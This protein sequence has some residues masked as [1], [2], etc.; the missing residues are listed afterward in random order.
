M[1]HERVA[2]I[3]EY[4]DALVG[5]YQTKWKIKDVPTPPDQLIEVLE[6]VNKKGF[7]FEPIYYPEIRLTE[8]SV[9]PGKGIKPYHCLWKNQLGVTIAED[10]TTLRGGWMLIESVQKPNYDNGQ[11]MYYDGKDP[12]GPKLQQL[13]QGSEVEAAVCSRDVPQ[14]SRFGTAVN[15]INTLVIPYFASLAGIDKNQVSIPRAIEFNI[16]GNVVHPEWGETSTWEW[17]ADRFRYSKCLAGGGSKGGGLAHV[18]EEDLDKHDRSI[19][20]RL[21]IAFPSV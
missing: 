2:R 7:S 12:L 19:G 6:R 13:R 9:F 10:A 4:K 14:D 18:H 3:Q 1:G 11:Q 8:D 17:F 16:A 21:Q 20:F 5:L 15:E